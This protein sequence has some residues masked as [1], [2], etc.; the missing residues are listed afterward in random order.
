MDAYERLPRLIAVARARADRDGRRRKV[1]GEPYDVRG[2][3]RWRWVI[4]RGDGR[5]LGGRWGRDL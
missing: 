4:Q 5:R 1:V 2:H 3:P